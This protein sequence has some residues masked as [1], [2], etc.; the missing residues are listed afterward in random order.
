MVSK[1][2]SVGDPLLTGHWIGHCAGI[3]KLSSP[4][5]GQSSGGIARDTS[6]ATVLGTVPC[7]LPDTVPHMVPR[8][9]PDTVRRRWT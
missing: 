2:H 3:I 4:L 9:L 6:P 1:K 5:L 7:I 8:T